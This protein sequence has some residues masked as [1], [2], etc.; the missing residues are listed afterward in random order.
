MQGRSQYFF[1]I[2]VSFLLVL[3]LNSYSAESN[4]TVKI[5]SILKSAKITK[6]KNNTVPIEIKFAKDN[7]M[8]LTSF[9]SA[10]S[11]ELQLSE[12]NTFR[13]YKAFSDNLGQT[14]HRYK[15]YY[16]GLEVA[17]IQYVV[18]EEKGMVTIANGQIIKGLN[19]DITPTLS[20]AEALKSALGQLNAETYIWQN[21]QNEVLIDKAGQD[22]KTAFYP[23]GKLMIS[24][25]VEKKNVNAY[26]LVY[27]FDIWAEKP[28]WRYNV[29]VDAHTGQIIN[30]ISLIQSGDISGEGQSLYDGTVQLTVSDSDY[31][32]PPVATV[33]WHAD[34]WN[35]F[36]GIGESFWVADPSIGDEGGYENGWYEVMDTDIITLEGD[37]LQLDFVHRY[38]VEDPAGASAPYNGWDGMNVRI[39]MDS[40]ATWQVLNNPSVAYNSSSLYS[41]GEIYGEGSGVA[42]W[43]GKQLDWTPVSFDLSAYAGKNIQI[44]FAF[45]SDLGLSTSDGAPDLF[46]WQVD[47]IAISNSESNIYFNEGDTSLVTFTTLASSEAEVTVVEGNYR[48]REAGRAAGIFTYNAKNGD[49]FSASEDFV[50]SD[51]NFTA[52]YDQ[53]GVSA[54]WVLENNYDYYL[55]AFNRD[56]YDGKG[57][58]IRAYVHWST[59]WTNAQWLGSFMRFGDADG[60]SY[61]SLVSIDVISHEFAH[62]V[63]QE[64]ANLIYQAEYGGLNESFSDIFGE[65]LENYM[66]G[67]VDWLVGREFAKSA[68]PFRSMSDPKSLGSPDT[69]EGDNWVSPSNLGFDNGGVHFNSGVQNYWFYLLIEGGSGTNDKGFAYNVT[70]IGFEDAQQIAYRNLS[71]YL[72]PTSEFSDARLGAINAAAD[73]FGAGSQQYN[74]VIDAWDAV[75]VTEPFLA[76][77]AYVG[78]DSVQ[79][80]AEVLSDTTFQSVDIINLGID[81]LTITNLSTDSENFEI[82]GDIILPLK[83]GYDDTLTVKMSFHAGEEKNYS[84]SLR[85]ESNDPTAKPFP[86]K[87]RGYVIHGVVTD[88]LYAVSDQSGGAVLLNIVPD[89]STQLIGNAGINKL[90]SLALNPVSQELIAT[91]LNGPNTDLM[92]VNTAQGDAHVVTSVPVKQM[93]SIAFKPG[94]DLLYGTAYSTGI[95]Y[96]VD[97]STGDTTRIGTTGATRFYALAFNPIDGQLY[98]MTRFNDLYSIDI[99]TAAATKIGNTGINNMRA[100]AFDVDGK[101][102]GVAGVSASVLSDLVQISTTDGSGV[103]VGSTGYSKV[104]GLVITGSVVTAVETET[105]TIPLKFS[106]MQNYPNPFNPQTTLAFGLA[107]QATVSLAVYNLAGQKVAELVSKKVYQAGQHKLTWL[108]TNQYGA[109]LATGVYVYKLTAQTKNGIVKTFT[110]K[111]ILIK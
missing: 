80:E 55:S 111:M 37:T 92:R 46:G 81:S 110:K 32:V 63:T 1:K 96:Q 95:L 33:K 36:D 13:P 43:G 64:T 77:T 84:D 47:K 11:A 73:L 75:G 52:S 76:A 87:G 71:V 91:D 53:A 28:S 65:S 5:Q 26:R 22:V 85:Y 90:Y 103:I 101:L 59:N 49:S 99:Q 44:R 54:H 27:R 50:D 68:S 4:D 16:K 18:H 67:E 39:S 12:L 20:E 40:G 74:S 48:L 88:K 2:L 21:T 97:F 60:V 23:K 78:Q 51:S 86:I 72:T 38:N 29:D 104:N 3:T 9:W 7:R 17:D 98:G 83:I 25:T 24:S 42:G 70:G 107:K 35:A 93:I 8:P 30:K 34:S 56:S 109:A 79:F 31:P 61:G 41:F 69:Y 89:S 14:H 57:S 108:A 102:M 82:V 94:T 105:E 66:K 106:L 58:R 62:G 10:Y 100:I 6:G 19:L 15:Q 45:A